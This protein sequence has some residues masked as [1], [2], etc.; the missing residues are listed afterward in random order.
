MFLAT[1]TGTRPGLQGIGNI[2]I[3]T[4]LASPYS[5]SEVVFEPTDGVD[6]LMPDGCARATQQ[7]EYWAA[8]SVFAE[9][10]PNYSPKRSK[11]M[12][13][14]R[15]K[16]IDTSNP[17][18]WETVPLFMDPI[19]V[20]TWFVLHQGMKY[21][22]GLILNYLWWALK[23][24]NK[25]KVMCSESIA[26]AMGIEEA[27]RVDPAMLHSFAKFQLELKLSK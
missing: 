2:L 21:D 3:R 24:D 16:R 23:S 25:N 8:S 6:H 18:K 27:W 26:A 5:H 20:A 7:N 15:F 11:Q 13:G 12:G 9:R 14:V 1:Y 19:P 22:R 4:R 10:L 17:N